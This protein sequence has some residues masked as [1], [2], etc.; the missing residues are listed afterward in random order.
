MNNVLSRLRQTRFIPIL[1]LT[2]LGVALGAGVVSALFLTVFRDANTSDKAPLTSQSQ[3]SQAP[4]TVPTTL[5]QPVTATPP[6]PIPFDD[7]PG[8]ATDTAT[9][10]TYFNADW[11]LSVRYPPDWKLVKSQATSP[12]PVWVAFYPPSS[13]LTLP[14]PNISFYYRPDTPYPTG[15]LRN[16]VIS[17]IEGHQSETSPGQLGFPGSYDI[18]MPYRGGTLSLGIAEDFSLKSVLKTMLTTLTLSP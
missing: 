8:I 4:F 15:L 5:S 1:A 16:I 18:V 7:I 3:G 6:T 10:Q 14:S 12:S 2:L 9:W 17:G 13:D 11:G